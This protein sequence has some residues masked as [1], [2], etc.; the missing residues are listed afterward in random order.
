MNDLYVIEEMRGKGVAG[1]LF[2]ACSTYTN[3]ND[4]AAMVWETAKDNKRAQ[5][6]YEKMGAR[7]GDWITYTI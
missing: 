1:K 7:P 4:Y 2:E 5:R 3:D 6:F